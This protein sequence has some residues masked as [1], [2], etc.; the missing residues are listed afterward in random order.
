L[1]K[2]LAPWPAL[3]I[4][5]RERILIAADLHLGLEYQ[6]AGDGI[7]IP[8]QTDRFLA[9]L[10]GL[11]HRYNPHRLLLL[12]DV[13]HGVPHTSF[14]ERK[15]IPRFFNIL[16]D[17]VEQIDITRGNHDGYLHKYL[18]DEVELHGSK[19]LLIQS[20]PQIAAFHGH[21]WPHPS[22]LGADLIVT[23]H[24]HPTVLLPTPI[25]VK[26]SQRVWVKG[27]C[28]GK[29]VAKMFLER[30]GIKTEDPSQVFQTEYGVNVKNP[31]MILMPTFN[32]LLGGLPINTESPKSLL[33]PLLG[34]GTISL[35]DFDV[36]LL[37]GSYL[38]KVSFLR[39][40]SGEQEADLKDADKNR[41]YL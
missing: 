12:G 5:S 2:I 7:S 33:G 40:I 14:Q 36:Y 19:G 10:R 1:I 39:E 24:N 32:D 37:E 31:N 41:H 23:G 25:G 13:K 26:I 22:F 16:L 9:E 20:D 17:E 8:Y 6:L 35:E 21:A 29:L 11:I 34:T 28:D 4:E 3:L 30:N 15:E 18:P 38:G 27:V